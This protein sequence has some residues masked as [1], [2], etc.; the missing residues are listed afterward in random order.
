MYIVPIATVSGYL[1]YLIIYPDTCPTPVRH[2][3]SEHGVRR[4]MCEC[5][6]GVDVR[7][8]AELVLTTIVAHVVMGCIVLGRQIKINIFILVCCESSW[9]MGECAVGVDVR[10]GTT[11]SLVSIMSVVMCCNVLGRQMN[12]D[13]TVCYCKNTIH[14]VGVDVR[15]CTMKIHDSFIC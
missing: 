8:G 5:S 10:D 2:L 13:F 9:Y 15:F 14:F 4:E 7:D 1:S 12:V 6:I 3:L 11:I